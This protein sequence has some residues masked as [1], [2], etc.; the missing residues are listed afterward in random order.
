MALQLKYGP[1]RHYW[2]KAIVLCPQDY[3]EI[4]ESAFEVQWER[5][6]HSEVQQFQREMQ[7]VATHALAKLRPESAEDLNDL[8][9]GLPSD[10]DPG[11]DFALRWLQRKIKAFRG[12]LTV[13]DQEVTV[14]D[15]PELLEI[16]SYRIGLMNL[17][18]AQVRDPNAENRKN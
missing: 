10:F 7:A 2:T 14:E 17:L 4:D 1:K 5:F 15:L 16:V 13:D 8:L 9:A 11:M 12:L 3:D 18:R 6:T